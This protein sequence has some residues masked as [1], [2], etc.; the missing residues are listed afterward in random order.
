MM[1]ELVQIALLAGYLQILMVL[2]NFIFIYLIYITKHVICDA[3]VAICSFKEN[4]LKQGNCV[5][6]PAI[7]GICIPILILIVLIPTGIIVYKYWW[8]KRQYTQIN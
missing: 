1:L 8:K 3:F 6:S 2:Y 4:Y 5:P 7:F